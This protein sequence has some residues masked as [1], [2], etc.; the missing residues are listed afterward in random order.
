M[1][2]CLA[3]ILA[4][5]LALGAIPA[6]SLADSAKTELSFVRIGNDAAEKA[7]WEWVIQGFE[8]A[9]P[10]IKILYDDAAIGEPM[11]TKLNTMFASGSGP[12]LIGH[13]I[14]S[15]A[16]RVELGHYQAIDAYFDAWEGKDDLLPSVLANGTYKGHT[17]GLG[18]SVTPFVFAY[19][20]DLFE[21]AGLDPEQPPTTWDQLA[22][23]ARKLTV[24]SGDEITQSGFCFPQTGG[25]MV[26]FDVFTF[27]NGGKFMDED[28]NPTMDGPAQLEVLNYL[29]GLLPDV[30]MV[31]SNSETN[32]FVKGLA[33]MTLINNVALTSMLQDPEYAGKVGV[34]LPPNNGVKGTFSGCNMLFIGR[35]CKNADAAFSFI[36]FALSQ[37][38]TLERA[39]QL[40]IPVTRASLQAEFAALDPYNAA[41]SECVENG[42]G[43]PR[44]TW[45]TTFQRIRNELVQ[46]VLFGGADAQQSLTKA[47]EDLL[48]EIEG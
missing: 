22:E 8:A 45:A 39:K 19:R 31:Y 28:S 27:G 6:I 23:Y 10:D 15:V 48:F 35:D 12:D 47:Q 4:L 26:E 43:M 36:E 9:N 5:M 37:E 14:L 41:R 42:T 7:Y 11:E 13:G 25:N 32:P 38:S 30:N 20:K 16:A 21:A 18:Y 1:K 33:A 2:K 34:A 44:A 46:A 29:S 24:K 17:Y 3:L 40:R